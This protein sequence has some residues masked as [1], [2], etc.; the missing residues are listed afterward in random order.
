MKKG[1]SLLGE[2]ISRTSMGLPADWGIVV[3]W[4]HYKGAIF[5]IPKPPSLP[6][7][8]KFPEIPELADYAGPANSEFWEKFPATPLP[9]VAETQIDVSALE[10]KVCKVKSSLTKAQVS[11]SSRIIEYLRFGA[12]AHQSKPLGKCHVENSK[13]T[14][15]NGHEVTD[16]IATWIVKKYAAGP[17]DSPPC[18]LFRTNQLLAVVQPS[19][20]RP[21]L[22]SE[23]VMSKFDL[24]AAY[25]QVPC[26]IEDLRLQGFMWLNKYFCET[27]QIFGAS[28]S[29]CNFDMLGET[30]KTI[31]L[32]D[33]NI[34]HNL[35]MRQVDDVPVVAPKN[36]GW[37]EEYS[38][39]YKK[40]CQDLNIELAP[41]CPSADKAFENVT[42]G[43][44]LGILFDS[45][46]MSWSLPS[47]KRSKTLRS[48]AEIFH[49]ETIHLKRF[50]KLMG[51]L[52]HVCQ[53][54]RHSHRCS[55]RDYSEDK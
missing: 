9:T 14:T 54:C 12:P 35:V 17:F 52:N 19:K 43:K 23:A 25:K 21:V 32:A 16:N 26:K 5:L 36:S 3:N 47:E 11:R 53:M 22:K 48:V 8:L 34:P 27:R 20:V 41:N 31:V 42:K 29:V 13:K 33:C 38:E 49:S 44:V 10:E 40:T 1:L 46:N 51:R 4:L 7:G 24:V 15:S 28:T 18:P 2:R 30:V 50:Q 55:T 39:K 37:C 6:A 45:E